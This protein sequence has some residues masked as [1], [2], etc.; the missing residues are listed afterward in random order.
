MAGHHN[1]HARLDRGFERAELAKGER[2]DRH[3]DPRQIDVGIDRR[4]PMAGEVLHDRDDA[5]RLHALDRGPAA[6]GHLRCGRAEGADPDH[7]IRG[8]GVDVEDRGEIQIHAQRE[9]PARRAV[10]EILDERRPTRG[11]DRAGA[12]RNFPEAGNLG[13]HA[14][15]F[16]DADE[17]VNFP[18]EARRRARVGEVGG[19]EDHS[20]GLDPAQVRRELRCQLGAR[21]PHHHQFAKMRFDVGNVRHFTS[22]SSRSFR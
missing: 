15:L 13:N 1:R 2:R 4:V 19:E 18:C 6:R 10:R 7:R 8:V 12:R 20:G 14:A 22:A 3:L 16:V 11:R 21:Q 9:K 5:R 17:R